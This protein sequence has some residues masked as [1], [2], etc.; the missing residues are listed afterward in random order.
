[1]GDS[2]DHTLV[3]NPNQLPVR[4]YG[5]KVQDNPMSESLLSIVTEDAEFCME[6][7][8]DGTI[9]YTNTHM[10]TDKELS[11][12]PYVILSSSNPWIPMKVQFPCN[13][14]RTLEEEVGGLR[15]LSGV[16]AH[17]FIENNEMLPSEE[18]CSFLS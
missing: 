1:M 5:T 16:R 11:E 14:K 15:H 7:S 2:L 13:G 12:C 9:V 6:L 17:D 4:Y 8:M 10:P 18:D 3:T